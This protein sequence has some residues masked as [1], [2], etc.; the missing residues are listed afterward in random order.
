MLTR[1]DV[2]ADVKVH[3]RDGQPVRLGELWRARPALLLWVR[4][5]G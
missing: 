5:F 3:D 2:L 4:H 1:A